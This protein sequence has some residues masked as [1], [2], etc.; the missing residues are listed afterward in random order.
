ME[1][2]VAA[3]VIVQ[4]QVEKDV[5]VADEIIV[6][7]PPPAR[8]H[9]LIYAVAQWAGRQ[10]AG[11]GNQGFLTSTGRYVDRIEGMAIA[12]AAG[13]EFVVPE[14]QIPRVRLFSEHLW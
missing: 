3:A 12:L 7:A 2:I 4:P 13:Q 11:P 14:D 1:T 10:A 6:S 9:H 8:H 5:P